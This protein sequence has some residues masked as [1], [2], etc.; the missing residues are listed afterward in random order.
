M[1][2]L[3]H[4]DKHPWATTR[5]AEALKREWGDEVDIAYYKSLPD[6]DK[7]DTIHILFS[8]GIGK[9]KDYI[10]KYRHK[11]F[12][13]LASQR[14]LDNF[15]DTD[16]DLIEI[17]KNTVCCVAFNPDLQ[18]KLKKL[19]GQDNVV[20]IPNGVDEKLFNKKFVVGYAGVIDD[21]KGYGLV[22]QACEE[23]GVEFKIAGFPYERM[24]EFYREID[25]LVIPSMSEGCNNPTLEA[26]AMNIPVIATDT[27]IAKILGCV[28]VERDV[29]SIK[30]A[31]S[32]INSRSL[33][34]ENYTWS[35]I[36][37]KYSQL[38]V[39]KQGA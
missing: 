25:C 28:I 9:I 11:V 5:R 21:H 32:K 12:T 34:L 39:E 4:A 36:A 15:F 29:E 19:I 27:G 13:S 24:P 20:Y 14:T 31:I 18:D 23:L 6:G 1:I 7:Y 8:G 3:I 22:M 33:I 10:L 16:E 38:Y 37:N 26:M 2:L 35:K 30:K 17:Y